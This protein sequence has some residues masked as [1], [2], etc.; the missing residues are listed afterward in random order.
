MRPSTKSKHRGFWP[1]FLRRVRS[2]IRRGIDSA[3]RHR[4]LLLT[5]W[6]AVMIGELVAG[7]TGGL[8]NVLLSLIFGLPAVMAVGF[9]AVL[10]LAAVETL[11]LDST[12]RRRARRHWSGARQPRRAAPSP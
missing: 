3:F 7:G 10:L 12:R 1:V 8:R 9:G 2:G 11:G 5:V 4:A 6:L